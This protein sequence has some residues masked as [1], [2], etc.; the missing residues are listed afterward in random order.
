[1]LCGAVSADSPNFVSDS[2]D[3]FYGAQY[4][5]DYYDYDEPDEP[6]ELL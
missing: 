6:D 5:V 4:D 1:M 3:Y 2:D